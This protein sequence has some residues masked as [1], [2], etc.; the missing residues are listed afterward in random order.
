MSITVLHV[1]TADLARNT[2]ADITI[3]AEYGSFVWE[4]ALFTAA[5][6]Q[7]EGPFAGN[8]VIEGGQPSPANNPN[9]PK[10]AHHQKEGPFAGNHVIEGGQPSPANN[11]NIP[12]LDADL[13]DGGIIGV[14]H[15]DLDTLGGVL[16]AMG[17]SGFF[18]GRLDSFWSLVEFVDV[19]GPHKL[20]QSGAS[21]ADLAYLHAF[22]AWSQ[23]N[24]PR[25]SRDE[26]TDITSHIRDAE[27][28]L[29]LILSGDEAM[30]QA[31][32]EFEKAG[33][34]LNADS[35]V[36][37]AGTYK[38]VVVRV[39]DSFVNHLYATPDGTPMVAVVALNTKF[40]SITVSFADT[41]EGV[42][43]REIV[44]SLWGPEAGGHDGIAG[45]PRGQEMT[46]ND[47]KAAVKA[48]A[49][50]L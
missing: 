46:E 22:W 28:A 12:K 14:S 44:Q 15:F 11:P 3:E 43:A 45:S 29:R 42:S 47:L 35:F 19:N 1:P 50:V 21:G 25:W 30:L 37:Q 23:A 17:L 31:G 24:R 7:K 4:G 9:I 5:H 38:G 33:E 20:A 48:V 40:K 34:K 16:R 39:S 27:R 26:V 32:L 49:E 10:L 36:E 8:H 18:G 2:V 41:P 13:D 6:H